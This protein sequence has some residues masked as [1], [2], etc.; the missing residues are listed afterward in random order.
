MVVCRSITSVSIH[1]IYRSDAYIVD[2]RAVPVFLNS[3]ACQYKIVV[4]IC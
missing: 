2:A 3:S 1:K 4:G